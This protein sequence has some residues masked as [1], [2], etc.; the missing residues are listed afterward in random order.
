MLLT[1]AKFYLTKNVTN[2]KFHEIINPNSE[3]LTYN[4]IENGKSM[5]LPTP[6]WYASIVYV[7]GPRVL[8]IKK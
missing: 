4:I 3:L 1:K 8:F 5:Y 7:Y 6:N 2:L